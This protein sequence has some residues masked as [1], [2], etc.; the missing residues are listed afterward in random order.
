MAR[1]TIKDVAADVSELRGMMT[2]IAERLDA[3]VADPVAVVAPK[4]APKAAPKDAAYS[5]RKAAKAERTRL[6]ALLGQGPNDLAGS[7]IKQLRDM[8]AAS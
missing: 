4:A 2:R 5:S 7:T 3:P 6:K 8:V 1:L